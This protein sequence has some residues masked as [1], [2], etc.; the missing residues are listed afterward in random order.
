LILHKKWTRKLLLL[1]L[2]LLL[3]GRRQGREE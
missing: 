3:P 2:L 1:L